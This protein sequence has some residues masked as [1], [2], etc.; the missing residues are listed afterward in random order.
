MMSD[1]QFIMDMKF[2]VRKKR[3]QIPNND[4]SLLS[5]INIQPQFPHSY[6][7]VTRTP[8]SGSPTLYADSTL[9][10]SAYPQ[11]VLAG[12]THPPSSCSTAKNFFKLRIQSTRIPHIEKY[13]HNT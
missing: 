8:V 10:P 6:T 4:C 11:V 12:I 13:L 3:K 5:C 9:Q 2:E 7:L 1:D